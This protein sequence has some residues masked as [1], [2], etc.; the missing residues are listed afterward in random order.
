[1]PTF[2]SRSWPS[3]PSLLIVL[4]VKIR[5]LIRVRYNAVQHAVST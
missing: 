3:S 4:L 1:M 5:T 2:A